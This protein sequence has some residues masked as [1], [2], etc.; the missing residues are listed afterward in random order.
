MY[1]ST[2]GLTR[3][4]SVVEPSLPLCIS[5]VFDKEHGHSQISFL[6]HIS[7]HFFFPYCSIY[8]VYLVLYSLSFFSHFWEK[9]L[10]S[11]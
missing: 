4:L 1:K 9:H 11:L 10:I 6:M 7:L 8:A 3:E 5:F 2:R